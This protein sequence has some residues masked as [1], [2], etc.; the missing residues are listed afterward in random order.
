[1]FSPRASGFLR[2]IEMRCRVLVE[3]QA[4]CYAGLWANHANRDK[5]ILE[6]AYRAG[7]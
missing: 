7:T 5:H 4:D 1:M 2:A 3:L 6:Q